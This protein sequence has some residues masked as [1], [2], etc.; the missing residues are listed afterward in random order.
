MSFPHHY[1]YLCG[2]AILE[3]DA[4]GADLGDCAGFDMG[5]FLEY[6]PDMVKVYVG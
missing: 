2:L 5:H 1:K 4:I 6:G 3:K